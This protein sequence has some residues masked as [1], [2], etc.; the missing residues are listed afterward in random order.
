PA[1]VNEARA[2]HPDALFICHPECRPEVTAMADAVLSTGGMVRLA[3][4]S[5]AR[6]FIIGTE[7]GICYRLKKENPEKEFYPLVDVLCP[8][9]KKTTAEKVLASLEHMQY[10]IDVE[11]EI[12]RRARGAVE[13][14]LDVS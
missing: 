11:R 1:M 8:N 4:E 3:R 6:E 14:M 7:E 5:D 13:R 2:E 10:E 9:M 12:A